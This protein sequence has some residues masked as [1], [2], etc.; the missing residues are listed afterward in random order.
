MLSNIYKINP[1]IVREYYTSEDRYFQT[2]ITI[3]FLLQS[4]I[5][6]SNTD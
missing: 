4:V 6:R 5:Y 3:F 1:I 2:S